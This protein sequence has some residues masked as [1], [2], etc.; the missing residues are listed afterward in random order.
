MFKTS[1]FPAAFALLMMTTVTPI[2]AFAQSAIDYRI[3]VRTMTN[4]SW[5]DGYGT[6]NW[7]YMTMHGENGTK[8]VELK[9][10]HENG[11]YRPKT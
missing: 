7:I 3:I 9:G 10:S 11:V 8:K 2:V 6:D 1:K 5:T 4:D